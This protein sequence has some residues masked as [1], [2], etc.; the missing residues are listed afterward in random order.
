MFWK[1]INSSI[2]VVEIPKY[3]KSA[4]SG[5][6]LDLYGKHPEPFIHIKL[7]LI[8][9]NAAICTSLN[10]LENN[11]IMNRAVLGLKKGGFAQQCELIL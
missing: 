8:V 4:E 10:R 7:P 3:I 11:K 9:S 2:E 1:G 5:A 6:L